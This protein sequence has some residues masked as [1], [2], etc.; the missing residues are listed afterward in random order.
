ML[1]NANIEVVQVG[2]I[3]SGAVNLYHAAEERAPKAIR[4]DMINQG[5]IND[6]E[7]PAVYWLNSLC[8][9]LGVKLIQEKVLGDQHENGVD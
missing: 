9:S 8:A 5:Y 3:S 6:V 2:I 4:E 7:A 1:Q